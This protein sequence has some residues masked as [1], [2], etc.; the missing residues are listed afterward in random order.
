MPTPESEPAKPVSGLT[1]S[2]ANVLGLL[3]PLAVFFFVTPTIV[4][5]FGA[6]HFGV[7]TLFLTSL[8]LLTSFD[9]GLSAGG[10]RSLG[11]AL[12]AG[13]QQKLREIVQELW[14]AYF[15][16]GLSSALILLIFRQAS[17][18][19]FGLEAVLAAGFGSY[20]LPLSV[21]F[22]FCSMACTAVFRAKESFVRLTVI[23]VFYGTAS[24]LGVA[25]CARLG[26]MLDWALLWWAAMG[27]ASFVTLAWRADRLAGG[28]VWLPHFRFV[29]IRRSL[30]YNLH[31]FGSQLA[32]GATYH[33]DKFLISYFLGTVSVGYY[34]LASSLS[35]K[36]LSLV[37]AMAG[38]VFPRSVRMFAADDVV[39]LRE[40][41]IRSTRYVLLISWP[42]L[43]VALL[44][45]GEFLR[46]WVGAEFAE[47]MVDVFLL[48]LVSYFLTSL[49]VVASQ[50]FNGIGNSRV[51]A[52]FSSLGA[53][54]N[55]VAC[56][57][58][59]PR[60][61]LLGAALASVLSMAQV[62]GYT[63]ALHRRLELGRF[64]FIGL[65][66][67]LLVIGMLQA[68]LLWFSRSWATGWWSL[69]ALGIVGWVFFYAVWF[70]FRLADEGD[71]SVAHRLWRLVWQRIKGLMSIFIRGRQ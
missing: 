19:I 9:F 6:A 54:I 15:F 28:L 17:W 1:N 63:H 51:G 52:I 65:W 41:Y 27:A 14:S 49:S 61:G 34:G 60:W 35:T 31:A 39:G 20:A 46:L 58:F 70:F 43:I 59:I 23:Q 25:A 37:A 50:V 26:W 30:S 22:G 5:G 48:L 24:W 69:L 29:E 2:V 32:A 66:S 71:R 33:A 38:F 56:L 12:H 53:V 64:P 40:T 3:I 47:K 7:L 68:T 45:G 67:N 16:L 10:V 11:S 18:E 42:M 13:G 8:V 62:F 55:L 44:L 36:L 57:I 4:R 21:F